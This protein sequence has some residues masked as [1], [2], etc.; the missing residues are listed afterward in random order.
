MLQA[1]PIILVITDL[2]M[3]EL[4]MRVAA[5][6]LH[7]QWG[8]APLEF[9]TLEQPAAHEADAYGA[10]YHLAADGS[11]NVCVGDVPQEAEA[12]SYTTMIA[13]PESMDGILREQ[14]RRGV[15]ADGM[16]IAAS[17]NEWIEAG[18]AALRLA[19]CA[20]CPASRILVLLP[21]KNYLLEDD[22]ELFEATLANGCRV[23]ASDVRC[24]YFVGGDIR[25]ETANFT[26]TQLNEVAKLP[27][28]ITP[29]Y[30]H[31][32]GDLVLT[33]PFADNH[34]G[35]LRYGEHGVMVGVHVLFARG[36]AAYFTR[37]LGVRSSAAALLG[38]PQPGDAL[39]FASMTQ[40][41]AA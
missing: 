23:M 2:E 18:F 9:N 6:A 19:A 31:G 26:Q 1:R 17:K 10:I 3:D 5:S 32:N 21:G 39:V 30:V 34:D 4:G 12:F 40:P 14:A 24:Y 25:W 38:Q 11:L 16:R 29:A 33:L 36:P 41:L 8:D 7:A 27:A 15:R 35:E 13:R 20:P 37:A 22:T 28:A